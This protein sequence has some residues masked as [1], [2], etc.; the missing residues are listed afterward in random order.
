MKTR[1]RIAETYQK[2]DLEGIYDAIVIGSGIGGLAAAALLAKHGGKRVLVLERH[3][4]PGGY[5]HT[6]H[7]PGYEWD[8]GVHYI[9]EMEEGKL[10]RAIF[11]EVT[12]AELKW[13]DMGD[14]YDRIIIGEEA[15]DF[16]KGRENLR[17]SLKGRFPADARAIDR[18]FTL[19]EQS[20]RSSFSFF[21]ASALP[22]LLD[23]LAG[24]Y[25]RR[26]FLG[27]ASQTTRQ[28]LESLTDNQ[29]LIALLTG[30]FGDYGL[31][32]A[33]SSFAMHAVVANHYFEGGYYPIGG[34][35]RI[36]ETIIP[37]ITEAGGKVLIN[38]EVAE[39]LVQNGRA[40]GVRMA[41]DGAIFRAPIVISDAGALNTY[42]RLLPS[43][44]RAALRLDQ[45]LRAVRPSLAHLCLYIGLKSTAQELNL[46]RA[47]LW[48]YPNER[49]EQNVAAALAN[50][51][52]PFPVVYVSFPSAK[53]PDFERRHPGR[54]TIDVITVASYDHFATW[55]GTSWKKRGREYE[56]LKERLARRLLDA[57]FAHVPQA[58]DKIDMY[59]LSTPLTTKH[60]SNYGVGEIYG[61]DHT[62]VRFRQRLLRPR[63]PIRGLYLTGQDIATCGVGGALMGGLLSAST[64]LGRN[65]VSPIVAEHLIPGKAHTRD[66][67]SSLIG[68]TK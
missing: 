52:A 57:L 6:F 42:S 36:A 31:A 23:S 13:A 50:I 18:Y 51:D 68:A 67:K 39:I 8:V 15:F 27:F 1:K 37:L 47:N 55:D 49:H 5:T 9:G 17:R 64:I 59:E 56:A 2:D 33:E 7:R 12:G 66:Q 61:L 30:Q 62:P 28:V 25:M 38:A 22:S 45:E 48:I 3:Y 65:L 46:P 44:T 40:Q 19:V 29:R 63:T 43:E 16:R 4:V 14:V 10:L 20:V 60:F 11:D 26:K 32:P 41:R 35:G 54:A 53:D 34:A 21:K 24:S 58:R